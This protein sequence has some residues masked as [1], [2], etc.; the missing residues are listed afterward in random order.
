MSEKIHVEFCADIALEIIN[1]CQTRLGA[2]E[3]N[4]VQEIMD[5]PFNIGNQE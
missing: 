3:Y 2:P 1:V 5:C 4:D